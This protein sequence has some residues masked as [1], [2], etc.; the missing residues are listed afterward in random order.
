MS[1]RKNLSAMLGGAVQQAGT[2]D[3]QTAQ[4]IPVARPQVAAAAPLRTSSRAAKWLS[5]ER[6]ETRQRPDQIEWIE[7]KRKD[8]NAMRGGEGERL[9]DN[10]LIRVAL[11]LLMQRG[12]DLTGTTEDELRRSLGIALA[13]D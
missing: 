4:E 10:T 11:D 7:A 12:D 2:I 9:T 5:F 8:L 6:K 3:V 1:A 13:S